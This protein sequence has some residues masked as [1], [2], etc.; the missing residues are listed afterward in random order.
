MQPKKGTLS[1][2]DVLNVE[3]NARAGDAFR[4]TIQFR[5]DRDAA[6]Q[7]WRNSQ[8][9]HNKVNETVDTAHRQYLAS[10]Y[11]TG[12]HLLC[13]W[14]FMATK[15]KADARLLDKVKSPAPN[16]NADL[17][18]HLRTGAKMAF[19]AEGEK[20]FDRARKQN[21][22]LLGNITEVATIGQR[23]KILNTNIWSWG[24]NQ[25]FIEGGAANGALMTL[26]TPLTDAVCEAFDNG[27]ITTGVD[28]IDRAEKLHDITNVT[29]PLWHHGGNRPT[30][31][32]MEVAGLLDLGYQL[33]PDHLSLNPPT[34][35][36]KRF[37]QAETQKRG[38]D[39]Y[40][41]TLNLPTL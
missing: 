35:G 6:E 39:A 24:V 13:G 33:G 8:R 11:T 3:G 34:D 22:I 25:A 31:Y 5:I 18:E 40:L 4:K 23:D 36:V 15:K 2:A 26:V 7:R 9:D 14:Y 10:Q 21:Q 38:T 17:M 12:V 41:T 20:Q 19:V 27:E 37:I 1:Y 16:D 28:L 30:W 32:A 29:D